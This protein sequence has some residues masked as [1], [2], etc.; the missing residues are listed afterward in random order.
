MDDSTHEYHVVPDRTRPLDFEVYAVT[1]VV[2]HGIGDRQRTAV[3]AVL[4]GLQQRQGSSAVGLLHDAPRAAAACRQPP[5]AEVRV[6]AMSAAS[7]SS[8]LVDPSQ[9]PYQRRLAPALDSDAVHQ[10]RSRAADADRRRPNRLVPRRRGAGERD[11]RAQRPEPSVRAAGRRR[12]VVA[13]GQPSVAQL[14]VAGAVRAGRGRRG[15]A[16]SAGA[17]RGRRRTR[18]RRDRSRGSA[19]SAS[20]A[21]CGGC[22]DADRSRSA[23]ASR[24]R[25]RWTRLAFEGASAFLLGS[26]L[27]RFFARHVSMNSFTETV[28]R[29]EARG[30]D[31]SMGATM[32]RET[33]A[34]AFFA[35][36]AEGAAPVDFT[37]R[38]AAWNACTADAA[39]LGTGAAPCRRAGAPRA[40]SRICPLRRRRWPQLRRA[41]AAAAAPAGPAFGLF[42]PNGPLPMHLTEY[43]RERLR[44]ADDPTLGRFLDVFH[45][46]FLALFYRAWAQ[47]QPTVN[48]DRPPRTGSP[49]YVGAF[50]GIGAGD[51]SRPRRPAG[52][53]EALSCGRARPPDPERRRT[54]A[55]PP[56]FFPACRS[57][58]RNSWATG[59][60]C[61]RAS[62][63]G[64]GGRRRAAGSRRRAR[65][66]CVGP[67]AQFPDSSR[68][69]DARRSTRRFL[70]GGGEPRS[71]LRRLGAQLRR[72]RARLGRPSGAEARRGAAPR[73]GGTARLGWTTWL[74]RATRGRRT[75]RTCAS[76]REA[77]IAADGA[78]AA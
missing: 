67:A 28:L 5:G 6:R 36:L 13:R 21:S 24:S 52:S 45:H 17:L 27:D 35:A 63:R 11:P 65:R 51:A 19:P 54:D 29:S 33:D 4:C 64:S 56:A 49:S 50:V 2:G 43:A 58:S 26:V 39:A 72:L 76:T 41:R 66:A 16:R 53:R 37:R 44:H 70:P 40:G 61:A 34:L 68:T 74:G 48:H 62:V 55:H 38:C 14:S 25:C 15:A 10:S 42:G 8:P 78:D 23:G 46:R 7:C 12:R 22:R 32:G 60:R 71:Q 20:A 57:R 1:D 77:S 30:R 69:A 3:P 18:A 75:P 73:L 9:A 47:A 31:L 59:C